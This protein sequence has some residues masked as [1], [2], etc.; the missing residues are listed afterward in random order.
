MRIADDVRNETNATISFEDDGPSAIDLARSLAED[1]SIVIDLTANVAYG[2]DGGS[3]NNANVATAH[4]NVSIVN[5]VATYTPTA[6]YNGTDSFTYTVIDGDGDTV[7]KTVTL[8]ITPEN[9]PP[10]I[11]TGEDF[12]TEDTDV[13]TGNVLVAS[14]VL[15]IS[16][17]DGPAENT[18]Q[19]FTKSTPLTAVRCNCWPMAPGPTR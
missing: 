13:Q 4:G 11:G 2:T 8:T 16:D 18:F 15:S 17:P 12:V 9:D 10:R 14:G 6:N 5:G 1:T 3:I 19:P 7:T